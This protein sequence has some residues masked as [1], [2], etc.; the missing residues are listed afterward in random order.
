MSVT[1]KPDYSLRIK[2]ISDNW[3]IGRSNGA[4][5]FGYTEQQVT[6]KYTLYMRETSLP[7][8]GPN[9][10]SH[11]IANKIIA[12]NNQFEASKTEH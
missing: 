9:V 5:F 12:L 11:R 3:F 4:A 7:R 10:D 2:P 8:Y 1:S 6:W